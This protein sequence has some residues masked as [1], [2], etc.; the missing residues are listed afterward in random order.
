MKNLIFRL[1]SLSS[2]SDISTACRM[3]LYGRFYL[4]V[5]A[6]GLCYRHCHQS[7]SELPPLIAGQPL[8]RPVMLNEVLHCLDIQPGQVKSLYLNI[9]MWLRDF[10]V[11]GV[12]HSHTVCKTTFH[13]LIFVFSFNTCCMCFIVSNYVLLV[14]VVLL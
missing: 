11:L 7:T 2:R 1:V 13:S 3:K 8:H 9:S 5:W 6:P 12:F 4:H 10:P 14:R